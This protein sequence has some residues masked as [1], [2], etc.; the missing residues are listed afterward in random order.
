[1]KYL[2]NINNW[3]KLF[4]SAKHFS[5]HCTKIQN[6]NNK[7][8]INYEIKKWCRFSIFYFNFWL[9]IGFMLIV[10]IYQI[11]INYKIKKWCRFSVFDFNFFFVYWISGRPTLVMNIWRQIMN[12]LLGITWPPI[13]LGCFV[14]IV[15]GSERCQN[16]KSDKIL[17]SCAPRC[18]ANKSV[19]RLMDGRSAPVS[20]DSAPTD[21][22]V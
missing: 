15:A 19:T 2:Y 13:T 21:V 14:K 1:M 11:S 17:V 18:L 10:F 4:Y 5:S 20:K 9:F 3:I 22:I 7:N 12:V 16:V 6:G 8:W